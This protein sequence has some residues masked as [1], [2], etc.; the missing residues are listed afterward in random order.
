MS[1]PGFFDIFIALV[2][3]YWAL[4]DLP[5]LREEILLIAGPKFEGD[6]ELLI[7][8]V[9]KVV[10]GYLKGQTIASLATGTLATI[11]LAIFHVPYA[12]VL[13]IIAFFLNYIPY[14]G[15]FIT[16]LIAGLVGL[17]RQP[18]G[19]GL[20]AVLVDRGRPELHRHRRHAAGDV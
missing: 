15:P 3:A 5:K 11:G 7:S 2:I 17:L 14:V 18:A 16:G 20:A 4:K 12:L 8:T 6:A 13:G 19:P 1:P 10:G 9:T